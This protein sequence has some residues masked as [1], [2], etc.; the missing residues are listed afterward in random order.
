MRCQDAVL[1]SAST[2][3]EPAADL[4]PALREADKT[5]STTCR[6]LPDFYTRVTR[7]NL[8]YL[9]TEAHDVNNLP[10]VVT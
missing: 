5:F 8:Y 1:I 2:R 4:S 6:Y 3:V 9:V 10:K 7:T